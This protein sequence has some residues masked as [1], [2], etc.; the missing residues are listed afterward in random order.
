MTVR[1]LITGLGRFK[2]DAPVTFWYYENHPE[3]R[4]DPLTEGNA[5]YIERMAEGTIDDEKG[6]VII[7]VSRFELPDNVGEE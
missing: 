5:A 4:E 2:P 6:H 7:D 3:D 1:D